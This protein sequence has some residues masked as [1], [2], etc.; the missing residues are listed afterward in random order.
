MVIKISGFQSLGCLD[1]IQ[2]D[3]SQSVKLC[4]AT[5]GDEALGAGFTFSVGGTVSHTNSDGNLGM[6]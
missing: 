6:P 3:H 5:P 2:P 4:N 1:V